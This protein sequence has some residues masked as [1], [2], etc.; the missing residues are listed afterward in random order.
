MEFITPKIL[1]EKCIKRCKKDKDAVVAITG[2]EGDGKSTLAVWCII[3]SLR[4]QGK[5]EEEIITMFNE[6]IIYSPTKDQLIEK[7]VKLPRYSVFSADEAIK[8][9]YKMNWYTDIQK[10]LN[11]IYAL[12]RKENK[13]TIL[14]MPRFTDFNEFFRNHRIRYWIHVL[15]R[16][17]AVLFAKDWSPFTKDPWWMDDNQRTINAGYKNKQTKV[18]EFD[19]DSK[20]SMLKKLKIFVTEVRFDDLPKEISK[21][22]LKGKEENS[23]YGDGEDAKQKGE[24]ASVWE[25]RAVNFALYVEK[26][27]NIPHEETLKVMNI[28]ENRFRVGKH[29]AKVFG[30][31]II[32]SANRITLN[33][34]PTNLED[35]KADI[36]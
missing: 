11:V 27:Y 26:K 9:L 8:I 5:T 10:F 14:C 34:T 17:R 33:K 6:Y 19:I 36:T 35:L 21:I 28:T 12:C 25:G 4:L 1:V 29:D 30:I 2:D 18:V 3:E 23:E 16:G 7:V 32:N 15:E 31:P 13:A 22:Y 20:I 24:K